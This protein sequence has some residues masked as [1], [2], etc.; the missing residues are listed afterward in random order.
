MFLQNF[1]YA[2]G[3]SKDIVRSPFART[4]CNE[5]LV[6]YRTESGSVVAMEDRCCHRRLPLRLG[7]VIGDNIQCAYHGLVYEPG[8]RCVK[9]PGQHL[10]PPNAQVRTFSTCDRHGLVWVF[11]GAHELADESRIPDYHWITDPEWGSKGEYFHVEAHYQ[12]IVENLLDLTH[13]AFVHA[14]T[15]G[16]AAVVENAEV[17][18]QRSSTSVDVRRIMRNTPPPPTYVKAG[19]FTGNID[20]WQYINFAPPC[21]VRL[22]TGG[23]DAGSQGNKITLRNL[24]IITPETD[25]T[26]HYLWAQC[27]DFDV[28]NQKTTDM[29]FNDVRTAFLQD[30]EIFEAQQTAI[31]RQPEAPEIDVTGDAGGLQ[32]RRIIRRM[33]DEQIAA[34]AIVSN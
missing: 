1:W 5:P 8:G 27:H 11:M 22:E 18:F 30:V 2:V 34:R 12:L 10:V 3:W 23:C 16:N 20:R 21:F 26:S 31:E 25:T 32:A 14:T 9:V 13:L 19:G 24:N 29:I 28:G 7:K 15:I 17:S 6:L 33:L 4:I